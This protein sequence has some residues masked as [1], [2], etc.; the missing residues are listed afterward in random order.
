MRRP[1]RIV[2][3]AGLVGGLLLAAVAVVVQRRATAGTIVVGA[4]NGTTTTPAAAPRIVVEEP[5]TARP[6]ALG[7]GGSGPVVALA[8]ANGQPHRPA[9]AFNTSTAVS[10][11][12]RFVLVIGS[13]ARP[14]E[15][16][17]R[18]RADSIHLI[19]ANPA[20]GQ[21]TIVGFPRDSWVEIPGRGRAKINDAM[22]RGGPQLLADTVRLLTGLPVHYY[23]LT[24]FVGLQ[25]MVDALGG[26]D[27][28]VPHRMND[29]LS[30]ARFEPGWHR[31]TGSQALAFSRNRMDVP[32]GDFSRSQNQG[33]L[34]QATLAKM[35]SEVGD[36]DGILR[37][38]AVLGRHVQLDVP[39]GRLPE[40]AVLGRRLDPADI[41]NV[42]APG[43]LGTAGGGSVVFLGQE[44]E[45]IFVDLRDDAV[46]GT[47]RPPAT[48][49]TRPPSTT[50]PAL[51]STSTTAASPL[52]PPSS[53]T[54][55]TAGDG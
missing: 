7:S 25:A 15:R 18:S 19:A 12:L 20:S 11:E 4:F 22:A 45:R 21:A 29:R 1:T 35:R 33:A 10:P 54:S 52:P 36:D 28:N 27:V 8:P 43:R 5:T 46:L 42:V 39:P 40:L 16:L 6:A 3:A 24:G 32:A 51:T 50:G 23:V 14:G 2:I 55:T 44:A 49:T 53:T 47:A 31:F 26:V 37:W 13:D 30:G 48:S 9:I 34:I 17:D 41:T 38:L